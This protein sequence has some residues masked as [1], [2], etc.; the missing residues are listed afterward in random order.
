MSGSSAAGDGTVRLRTT[1]THLYRGARLLAERGVPDGPAAAV[2]EFGDGVAVEAELLRSTTGGVA[3][4][5]P[6]YRTAAGTDLAA[7]SWLVS[8]AEARQGESIV[9][10]VGRRIDLV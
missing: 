8:A 6:A 5:V 10:V 9:L 2:I 4:Q 7:K 3:L 1:S